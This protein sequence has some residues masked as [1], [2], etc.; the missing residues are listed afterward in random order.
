MRD[1]RLSAAMPAGAALIV[2]GIYFTSSFYGTGALGAPPK[3]HHQVGFSHLAASDR[4]AATALPLFY[5]ID[6]LALGL[7]AVYFVRITIF[8][9]AI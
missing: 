3:C 9:I 7:Y 1:R 8:L 6:L 4:Q 2:R 5:S